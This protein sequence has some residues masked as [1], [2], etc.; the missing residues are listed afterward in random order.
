M[1]STTKAESQKIFR[2]ANDHQIEILELNSISEP[3]RL[4][5]NHMMETINE[6]EE[7]NIQDENPYKTA[8]LHWGQKARYTSLSSRSDSHPVQST[9]DLP[10]NSLAD[11]Y[12]ESEHKR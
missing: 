8:I 7:A 6:I 3:S 10:V 11:K 2:R 4:E 9:I 12:R 1:N 5:N